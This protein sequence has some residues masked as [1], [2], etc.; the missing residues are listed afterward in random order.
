MAIDQLVQSLARA[1][2]DAFAL[3]RHLLRLVVL[4]V[5]FQADLGN[6]VLLADVRRELFP[7]GR[8]SGHVLVHVVRRRLVAALR[9]SSFGTVLIVS[10]EVDL[11]RLLVHAWFKGQLRLNLFL[12]FLFL[13]LLLFPQTEELPVRLFDS[14][15]IGEAKVGNVDDLLTFQASLALTSLI[16]L[17]S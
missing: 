2:L 5:V 12:L 9:W 13:L 10:C 15:V 4:A 8:L 11:Q 3:L 6:L 17:L 14:R 1:V 7:L 16:C